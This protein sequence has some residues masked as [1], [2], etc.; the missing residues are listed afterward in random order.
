MN[1][2]SE[3]YNALVKVINIR[4]AKEL[5]DSG[6]IIQEFHLLKNLAT[7]KDCFLLIVNNKQIRFV[8]P[9]DFNSHFT[10]STLTD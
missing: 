9:S 5:K 1:Y 7:G 3:A 4:F 2:D 8:K 10:S 6:I